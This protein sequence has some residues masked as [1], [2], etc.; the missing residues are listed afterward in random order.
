MAELPIAH[1]LGH[2]LLFGFGAAGAT[3]AIWLSKDTIV[4]AFRSTLQENELDRMRAEAEALDER[5]R[6][7]DEDRVRVHQKVEARE[8]TGPEAAALM[9]SLGRAHDAAREESRILKEQLRASAR[10]STRAGYALYVVFGGVFG[11][12]FSLVVETPE[13]AAAQGLVPFTDVN[14]I[15]EAMGV[16]AAWPHFWSRRKMTLK[17]AEAAATGAA[18]AEEGAR[19]VAELEAEAKALRQKL[20]ATMAEGGAAADAREAVERLASKASEAREGLQKEAERTR[21]VVVRSTAAAEAGL[22]KKK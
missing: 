19:R 21:R 17:A 7:L 12:I 13:I 5:A 20:S 16:G 22:G 9:D 6:A 10:A 3:L 1:Y 11:G 4:P 18:A 15:M 2:V 8:L 14:T